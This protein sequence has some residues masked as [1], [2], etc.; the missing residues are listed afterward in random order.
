[1]CSICSQNLNG[2]DCESCRA[3]MSYFKCNTMFYNPVEDE[4]SMMRTYHS[5]LSILEPDEKEGIINQF[6]GSSYYLM[7]MD[8]LKLDYSAPGH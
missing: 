6:V 7:I 5:W 4:E 3:Y 2:L 1:M 8:E